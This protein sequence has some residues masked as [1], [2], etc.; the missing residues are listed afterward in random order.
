MRIR[1]AFAPESKTRG[2]VYEYPI[3][4]YGEII[5]ESATQIRFN[6]AVIGDAKEYGITGEHTLKPAE[7]RVLRKDPHASPPRNWDQIETT[8]S[9]LD[10]LARL[11]ASTVE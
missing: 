11:S 3:M 4:L 2:N 7:C 10:R 6:V 8:P 9:V 5:S 1:N